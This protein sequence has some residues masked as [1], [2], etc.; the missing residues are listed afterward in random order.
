MLRYHRPDWSWNEEPLGLLEP[1]PTLLLTM[2]KEPGIRLQP[3]VWLARSLNQPFSPATGRAF[4]GTLMRK[5]QWAGSPNDLTWST[6]SWA[7]AS[8]PIF[9]SRTR[10]KH[11]RCWAL[12]PRKTPPPRPSPRA[13]PRPNSRRDAAPPP[14]QPCLHAYGRIA[15]N[16]V[17]HRN[18]VAAM[19]T[20][21]AAP[22]WAA[23]GGRHAGRSG[24]TRRAGRAGVGVPAVQSYATRTRHDAPAAAGAGRAVAQ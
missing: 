19:R 4:P 10:S 22:P 13:L 7:S 21:T 6:Q 2:L 24:F 18:R 5:L 12:F 3:Y 14:H 23:S 9:H 17:R 1:G 16:Q 11:A 15:L 8:S 20:H